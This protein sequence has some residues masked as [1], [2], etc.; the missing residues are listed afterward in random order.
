MIEML[1]VFSCMLLHRGTP[2]NTVTRA[3]RQP[4]SAKCAPYAPALEE[5]HC[6]PQHGRNCQRSLRVH[7]QVRVH[8]AG[9]RRGD[10]PSEHNCPCTARA[11]AAT[12][13]TSSCAAGACHHVPGQYTTA[14]ALYCSVA[15]DDWKKRQVTVSCPPLFSATVLN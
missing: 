5:H 4:P 15:F 1:P 7:V 12:W 2:A 8:D 11:V 6:G 14:V 10:D 13:N 3:M 9:R